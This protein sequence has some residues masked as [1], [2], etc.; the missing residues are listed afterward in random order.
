MTDNSHHFREHVEAADAAMWADLDAHMKKAVA[1]AAPQIA[2][3]PAAEIE[4]ILRRELGIAMAEWMR[5][6]EARFGRLPRV[7]PDD[8]RL[9]GDDW[10]DAD[11]GN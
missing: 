11:A 3:K 5:E 6:T 7:S 8:L 2:G 9:P 10:K 1:L 4:E